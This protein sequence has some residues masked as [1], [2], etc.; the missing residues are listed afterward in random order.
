MFNCLILVNNFNQ[1]ERTFMRKPL[2]SIF[3]IVVIATLHSCVPNGD[4]NPT[5]RKIKQSIKVHDDNINGINLRVQNLSIRENARFYYN[6]IGL[7]DSMDVFS[8]TTASATLL[9]SLKLV[10]FNDKVRAFVYDTSSRFSLDLY[11]NSNRQITKMT[12]TLGLG[13]GF[14]FTYSNNKIS[15]LRISLD[16]TFYYTNFMYDGNNNLTQFIITDKNSQPL[17]RVNIEYDL[18]KKIPQELD[19]K[20]ASGGIRFLYAG[21]V[22]VLSLA[23]LNYG[24]GNSN[25]I[26]KRIEYNLQTAQTGNKYL[27]DYTTNNNQEITNRKIIVNDTIDVFYEY[28]Y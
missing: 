3:L 21:G 11:F 14:F 20:F 26:F 4:N 1:R 8:D 13:L 5:M 2:F 24:L 16:S 23:N 28:R 9:K 7:L 19:I 18:D 17:T 27:F 22:N 10:Y 25:R 12:D 6:S 15:N